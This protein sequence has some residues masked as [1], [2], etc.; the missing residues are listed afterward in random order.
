M[1]GVHV[2][3]AQ[4]L[5][6]VYTACVAFWNA[7][8]H[9]PIA[10][11]TATLRMVLPGCDGRCDGNARF[12]EVLLGLLGAPESHTMRLDVSSK[13]PHPGTRS[14][15][16][17]QLLPLHAAIH[18]PLP[19]PLLQGTVMHSRKQPKEHSFRWVLI[20]LVSNALQP[21]H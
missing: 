7:S 8:L 12:Y 5:A 3:F 14:A 1:L 19:L 21:P 10:L 2:L 13:H 18:L 4:A 9:L 16:P 15:K 11:A 20:F 6:L 17:T